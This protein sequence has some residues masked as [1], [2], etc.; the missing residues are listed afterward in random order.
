MSWGQASRPRHTRGGQGRLE[1][2]LHL[3]RS[4]R[5]SHAR[6]LMRSRQGFFRDTR[7]AGSR[8]LKIPTA[9][10]RLDSICEICPLSCPCQA[11][12]R[13]TGREPMAACHPLN[14]DGI[15]T[16][17]AMRSKRGAARPRSAATAFRRVDI[18]VSPIIRGPANHSDHGGLHS[19]ERIQ[20]IHGR[21]RSSA[22]PRPVDSCSD[23][24]F[25]RPPSLPGVVKWLHGPHKTPCRHGASMFPNQKIRGE[26]Q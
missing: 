13:T 19:A 25:P 4:R 2:Q 6:R 9:T 14:A 16:P 10:R 20:L 26:E 3:T 5:H 11:A 24:E 21:R 1:Q 8:S 18:P 22:A 7:G 17:L 23:A 15:V 12:H